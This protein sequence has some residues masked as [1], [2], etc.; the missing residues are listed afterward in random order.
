MLPAK[1]ELS[2]IV[3]FFGDELKHAAESIAYFTAPA[4]GA[5]TSYDLKRPFTSCGSLRQ[6]CSGARTFSPSLAAA[7]H[8]QRGS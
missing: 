2:L 4:D 8:G 6:Y 5:V 1:Y 7:C 3:P